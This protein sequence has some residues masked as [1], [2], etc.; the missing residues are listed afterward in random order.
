[1]SSPPADQTEQTPERTDELVAQLE[2]LRQENS[3]LRDEYAR[4]KQTAYRRTSG[5]LAGLGVIA[6][7]AAVV[8]P[9]LRRLLIVLAAIGVF[10]GVLT[11]FLTPERV[12]TAGVSD[13]IYTAHHD[14][15]S[16]LTDELGLTAT[17]IYLPVDGGI[18]LFIP[19]H[20][21]YDLPTSDALFVTDDTAARGITLPPTGDLL[22][23]DLQTTTASMA[24]DSFD[25]IVERAGDAVVEQFE[26]ADAVDLTTSDSDTA[27]RVVVEI[28]GAAFGDLAQFDH[29][30]VSLLGTVAAQELDT[31]V[32]ADVIRQD[33]TVVVTFER[34]DDARDQSGPSPET[35]PGR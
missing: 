32:K 3:R 17:R 27:N 4:A 7:L 19:K 28:T 34:L 31:A 2:T 25:T 26:I 1:M 22:A 5:A 13:S 21:D 33:D 15:I 20:H 10:G 29:P 23:T 6:G 9:T 18:R 30:A 24:D 14:A 35:H 16:Q 11:R 12:V 8:F